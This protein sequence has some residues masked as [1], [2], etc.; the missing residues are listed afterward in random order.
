MR[1]G[2]ADTSIGQIHYT[3]AG[4]GAP[5]LLLGSAGRSS[6]M[7]RDLA[8]RLAGHRR[9]VAPDLPGFGASCPMPA[10]TTIEQLADLM[11]EFLDAVKAGTDS[12]VYGLHTGNKI[13]VAMA[14]RHPQRFARLIIAGQTHSLIPDNERRNA[15]IKGLIASYVTLDQSPYNQRAE[16][17]RLA[18]RVAA[19]FA[20]GPLDALHPHL[21]G[22]IADHVL[23]DVEAAATGMLYS[24]NLGFDLAGGYT[25]IRLPTSV[26]EISTS[27]EASHYGLQGEAVRAL[28]PHAHL[29]TVEVP[30]EGVLTMENHADRLAPVI[31]ACLAR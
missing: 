9:V 6:R 11:I 19:L 3:E 30:E 12:A 13:A 29:E 17:D 4:S 25:S 1:H 28:I 7:F 14:G 16:C 24:A 21:G 23:D 5:L 27:G 8:S 15:S 18:G 20:L 2:Y 10:G 26:L 22:R 31:L